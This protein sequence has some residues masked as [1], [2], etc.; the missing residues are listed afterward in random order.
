MKYFKFVKIEHT[1]F[2][3]PVVFAGT[4]LGLEGRPL[5]LREFFWIF[6][7]VLGARSAGFGLN[8]ILDAGLD[9]RN[10][11][12]ADREIPSGKIS[13]SGA[14]A[15]T[16][17]SALVFM[18]SAGRLSRTCFFL[19]FIPLLFFAVYPMLKR[20]TVLCHLGLGLAWGIAPLG[21]WFAVHPQILPLSRHLPAFLLAGFCIFWV[22]G[23]DIIYSLLD[24]TFDRD[25]GIYSL[26]SV[27]GAFD[28]LRVA[29]IFHFLSLMFL[30]TLV[31]VYLHYPLSFGF[32]CLAGLLLALSHWR[33]ANE[34]LSAPV[35]DFAFFKMNAALAFVVFLMIWIKR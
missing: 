10:P 22:A 4:F 12:T 26:P 20:R 33:V 35:I 27:L 24:E 32:L 6:L 3:L 18:V 5:S 11:R 9:A 34:P 28:A 17:I 13:L 7:A 29:R 19:S 15:F 30:G 21:G 25:N 1:L 2:S 8:R 16:G 14:W 23:F 31:R